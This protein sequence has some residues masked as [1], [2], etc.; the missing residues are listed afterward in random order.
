[1]KQL[2]KKQFTRNSA[3]YKFLEKAYDY[4]LLA[5][6][7]IINRFYW[8][9]GSLKPINHKKIVIVNY[10]GKGYSDNA[11]AIVDELL[12]TQ[13]DYEIV[14]LVNDLEDKSFNNLP[15]RLVK[16]KTKAAI[17][18]MATAKLWI[19][20]SRKLHYIHKRSEQLYLQTWHGGL[21]LK[22]IEKDAQQALSKSYIDYAIKD[23]S[24]TDIMLS[25]S[26][27]NTELYRNSFWYKNA[28]LE[29]GS[30]RSDSLFIDKNQITNKILTTYPTLKDKLVVLYA[31]TFRVDGDLSIYQ[32]DFED[33]ALAYERKYQQEVVI[34]LRLHPN[35]AKYA[36]ELK[37]SS[38]VI[39]AS[40]YSDMQELLVY[41]DILITDYSSSMFDMMLINKPVYLYTNDLAAYQQE[42]GF[43]FDLS[44]LPFL[45]A[46]NHRELLSQII[47]FEQ[48]NYLAKLE[49]FKASI[50]PY[51]DGHASSRVVEW[52]KT[53]M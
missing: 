9:L 49:E 39:D 19:D 32:L 44:K 4:L 11:K 47:S 38:S 20:N 8:Y 51:D 2:I 1:M 31:P 10:Y 5:N 53:Q 35:I 17:F 37:L 21:A 13:P 34:L 24:F 3:A 25:N 28:I 40:N 36:S 46:T 12:K 22:K 48:N 23:S 43:Y 41:S 45:Q 26:L 16:Y 6:D 14:W 7:Q 29:C 18:E 27:F 42:R 15:I 30:P 50:Q 33:I 52:I